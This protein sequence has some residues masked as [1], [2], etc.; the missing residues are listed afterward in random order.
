MA[1]SVSS[2]LIGMQREQGKLGCPVELGVHDPLNPL[3]AILVV[4]YCSDFTN[5]E[6][7]SQR[8]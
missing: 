1:S 2:V 8:D 4:G 3:W 6:T 7:K 5:G